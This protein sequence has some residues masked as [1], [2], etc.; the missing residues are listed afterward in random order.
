MGECFV[1]GLQDAISLLGPL[2]KPWVVQESSSSDAL[3]HKHRFVNRETETKTPED[4]RLGPLVDWER[5]DRELEADHPETCDWFRN[6][7]TGEE[8]AS[9]PRMTAEALR[10]RGVALRSFSLI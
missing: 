6:K 5:F 2:P 1:Y 10:A 3:R 4:P 9:D 7:T 8:M